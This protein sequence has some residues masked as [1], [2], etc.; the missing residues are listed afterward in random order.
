MNK[1]NWFNIVDVYVVFL[2]CVCKCVEICGRRFF[3]VFEIFFF[4]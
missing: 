2:E 3:E 1:Y 4:R